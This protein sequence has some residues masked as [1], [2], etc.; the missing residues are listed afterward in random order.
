[1]RSRDAVEAE[2]VSEVVLYPEMLEAGVEALVESRRRKL[3]DGNTAIAVWLAMKA[4]E[5][6][7]AMRNGESLH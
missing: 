5:E 7:A 2:E 1:M 4:I 6:I 3:D